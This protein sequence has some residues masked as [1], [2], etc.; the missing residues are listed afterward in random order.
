MS[1]NSNPKSYTDFIHEIFC[2]LANQNHR[3]SRIVLKLDIIYGVESEKMLIQLPEG[4][5][6]C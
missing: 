2:Q 1:D 5:C 4:F 3:H 6:P